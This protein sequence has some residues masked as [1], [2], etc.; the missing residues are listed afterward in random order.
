MIR[1]TTG[2]HRKMRR[3]QP[4]HRR[5]FTVLEMAVALAIASMLAGL[6][7]M[8][9]G[10]LNASMKRQSFATDLYTAMAQSRSRAISRQRTQ[11]MVIRTVAAAD[12]TFGYYEFED[13]A[14]PPNIYSATDL[15]TILGTLDPSKFNIT[16]PP[17][18]SLS[19]VDKNTVTISPFTIATNSW[20]G[21]LPFPFAQVTTNTSGGCSFCTAGSGAVAFL[22]NGKVIF[23]DANGA[24]GLVVVQ[25]TSADG[26]PA[27]KSGVAVSPTGFFQK[28]V[29]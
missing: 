29:P 18:Y 1:E 5:A 27:T 21:T 3:W 10:G 9:L 8:A 6:G 19:L 12:G 16:T 15:S 13:A 24:G 4:N 7:L 25:S 11:V 28:L 22:P 14:A 23:S 17:P 20:G 26:S 2:A